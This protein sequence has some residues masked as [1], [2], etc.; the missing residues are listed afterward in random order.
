VV[1]VAAPPVPEVPLPATAPTTQA[2]E[3]DIGQA[4]DSATR[5]K[6]P[7]SQPPAQEP[8]AAKVPSTPPASEPSGK[9]P[10]NPPPSLRRPPLLASEALMEDLAPLEPSR[11]QARFWCAAVGLS[12]VG[13]GTLPLLGLRDGGLS[14]ALPA[15]VFGGVALVAALARVSYRKRAVAMLIIG[16]LSV[17][18]GL[19][20]TGP[21]AGLSV[22]G[23]GAGL[24]RILAATALPAALL[25]RAR[26]R[27]YK[28]A[29]W[30]L[31]AGFVLA[32]PFI[33]L[34]VLR[35]FSFG[36]DLPSAGAVLA[37]VALAVSLV[38][39][40]GSETTGAGTYV[41]LGVVFGLA[42]DLALC[43]FGRQSA[44]GTLERAA[45]AGM[46]LAAFSAATGLSALGLFQ[47]LA[48]RFSSDAR[49]IDIHATSKEGPRRRRDPSA[50]DWSTRT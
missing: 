9:V 30:L 35:L 40:M 21:A 1:A 2:A 41:G 25:F 45:D 43:A 13:L 7:S 29:R 17:L 20:G 5:A 24:A 33:S 47:V 4:P 31:G 28:G 44:A 42:A 12:L 8:E 10:S 34:T 3:N 50:M 15:F 23:S 38:G 32:L 26:Y 49:R 14:A 6:P 46:A 36:M 11:E 22:E 48:W 39:F 37:L 27:A 18:T 16:L 19:G